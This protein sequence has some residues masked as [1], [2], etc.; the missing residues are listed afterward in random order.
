MAIHKLSDWLP[1]TAKEI[2]LKGWEQPDIIIVSGDAYVD[3][4]GFGHAVIARI[5]EQK[6]YKV[7]I[8]PQPNWKDDLLPQT[9][10]R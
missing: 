2:A 10:V 3:H 7:A 8:L 6:G 4:P 9:H 5:L 1:T